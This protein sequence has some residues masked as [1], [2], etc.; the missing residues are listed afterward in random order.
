[1]HYF[2]HKIS[3]DFIHLME[4]ELTNRLAVGLLSIFLPIYLY[5]L[6]DQDLKKV[7][8]YQLAITV[9]YFSSVLF[10]SR[11]FNNIG[12]TRSLGISVFLGATY[13]LIFFLLDVTGHIWLLGFTAAFLVLR[14]FF[15]WTPYHTLFSTLTDKLERG[16][17]VGALEAFTSLI[18]LFA[19]FL[20]G[21]VI[22]YWGYKPLFLLGIVIFLASYIFYSQLPK[23]KNRFSWSTR[24]IWRNLWAKKNH[25]ARWAFFSEGFEAVFGLIVWPIF[26]FELLDGN[27]FQVGALATLISLATML[28]QFFAGRLVDEKKSKKG[29]LKAGSLAYSIIWVFKI[30]IATAFQ[31]FIVDTLHSF[32]K[33]FLRI[34]FGV[35]TYD[36]FEEKKDLLDEYVTLRELS[37]GMGK[38]TAYLLVIGL[39]FLVSLNWLFILAALA[40]MMLNLLT[41]SD[42]PAITEAKKAK[43]A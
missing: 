32:S 6:L 3:L 30:F 17:E 10:F 14:A 5:L 33:I 12:F 2:K 29:L 18:G 35:L 7:I 37:I 39:S 20:A 23:S 22:S 4:G 34:P 8:L 26:I 41:L 13:Y 27:F 24:E 9:C 31:I 19:P 21:I 15:R 25:R 42:Q 16:K 40:S 28:L 1:M 43:T 36:F 11:F 38:M